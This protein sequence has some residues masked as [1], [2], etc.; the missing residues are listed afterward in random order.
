[1]QKNTKPL[2]VLDLDETLWHGNIFSEDHWELSLRPYLKEFLEN[3]GRSYNLMVWTAASKDWADYGMEIILDQTGYDLYQVAET[4]WYRERCTTGYRKT[5]NPYDYRSGEIV[6]YKKF[7]KLYKA[8]RFWPIEQILCL[9]DNKDNYPDGYGNVVWI[10][11][12]YGAADDMELLKLSEYLPK[13]A[14]NNNFREIEKRH[15]SDSF[16]SWD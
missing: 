2:L 12:W 3:V 5:F 8:H 11:P 15:W 9:D 1:M 13:L 16:F 4:V 6:T 14:N 10:R 7:N